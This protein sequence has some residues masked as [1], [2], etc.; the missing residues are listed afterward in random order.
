VGRRAVR[1]GLCVLKE[2][3]LRKKGGELGGSGRSVTLFLR[4]RQERRKKENRKMLEADERLA[5]YQ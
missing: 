1:E 4:L 5:H 3:D 2:E